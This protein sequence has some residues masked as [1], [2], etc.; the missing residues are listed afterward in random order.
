MQTRDSG[1]RHGRLATQL[2][3]EIVA[4]VALDHPG[5][6]RCRRP[7]ARHLCRQRNDLSNRSRLN[8]RSLGVELNPEYAKT[9][10]SPVAPPPLNSPSRESG[11]VLSRCAFGSTPSFSA[12][13]GCSRSPLSVRDNVKNVLSKFFCESDRD[14]IADLK[15]DVLVGTEEFI[16]V[17]KSL[18]G[19]RLAQGNCPVL[20]RMA[21]TS[22]GD[23]MT[24]PRKRRS[25]SVQGHPA[26]DIRMAVVVAFMAIESQAFGP[27]SSVAPVVRR[28]MKSLKVQSGNVA[29]DVVRHVGWLAPALIGG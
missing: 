16:A 24:T 29:A 12:K 27:R 20:S 21:I 17:R 10:A 11:W 6:Q 14:R 26:V 9:A 19:S 23:T 1:D 5:L 22:V 7:R 2:S 25:G 3:F 8:R 18:Q 28:A 4:D 13:S 15:R